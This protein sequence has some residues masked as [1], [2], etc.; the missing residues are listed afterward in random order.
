[1]IL[2]WKSTSSPVIPRL[3]R[4]RGNCPRH[5]AIFWRPC[6][7]YSTRTL[8]TCC[9]RLQ[10]VTVMNINN[11]SGILR[12]SVHN[13]K[14]IR[15]RVKTG[16]RTHSVLRQG[17]S[18]LQKYKAA[19]LSLQIAVDQTSEGMRLGWRTPRVDSLK[20]VNYK[21]IENAHE[22]RKKNFRILL[23][24]CYMCNYEGKRTDIGLC[25]PLGSIRLNCQ[26]MTKLAMKHILQAQVRNC[27]GTKTNR[28]LVMHH[29]ISS[30]KPLNIEQ[31]WNLAQKIN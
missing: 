4:Q 24:D 1:M 25:E 17:S 9:C 12:Q 20:L 22:V 11:I 16:S 14:N 5:A 26:L 8:V 23:W 27:I 28:K 15:Q 2:L 6:A 10:L 21:R 19:R 18:Q 30:I 3:K 29:K 31:F 13:C 7:Y